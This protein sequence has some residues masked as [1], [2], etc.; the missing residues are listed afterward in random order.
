MRGTG[1]G[2]QLRAPPMEQNENCISKQDV[3]VQRGPPRT[4]PGKKEKV[5]PGVCGMRPYQQKS[6]LPEAGEKPF[7]L[8]EKLEPGF[9]PTGVGYL[10]RRGRR[11]TVGLAGVGGF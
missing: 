2:R 3:C 7:S 4:Q 5:S 6:L 1:P 8:G 10:M 9:T 11:E